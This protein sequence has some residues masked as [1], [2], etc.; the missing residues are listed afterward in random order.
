M[1]SVASFGMLLSASEYKAN[2]DYPL[3]IAW[4]K[5]GIK[6]ENINYRSEYINLVEL[7]QE[8]AKEEL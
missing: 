3:I 7:V 4:A 2:A 6:V 8:L 1:A 5:G